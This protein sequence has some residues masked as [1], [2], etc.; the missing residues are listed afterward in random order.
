MKEQKIYSADS[1]IHKRRE[2]GAETRSL[3]YFVN[4][5]TKLSFCLSGANYIAQQLHFHEEIAEKIEQE[6][7]L[8]KNKII[9]DA[10]RIYYH[11]YLY[12]LARPDKPK[13]ENKP[14][15]LK[16]RSSL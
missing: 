13:E 5:G 16:L 9:K 6:I 2:L 15:I 3:N 8:T 4:A 14:H 7:S 10:K 1:S 12:T 11:R